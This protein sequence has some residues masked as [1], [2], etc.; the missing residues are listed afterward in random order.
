V[1]ELA[2]A[3]VALRARAGSRAP[4]P[5]VHRVA[6]DQEPTAATSSRR[7]GPLFPAAVIALYSALGIAAY[8]PLL[9]GASHRLPY[10][11]Y[12]DPV[13]VVWFFGWTAHALATAHNPFF[14]TAANVPYGVN[15]AQQTFAPLLGVLFAPLTLLV[16]PVSS[17]TACFVAAMP[18]SAASAYAVL[19]RWRLWAPAAALGGLAYGFSPFVVNQ[20]TQHLQFEF[21][22]LPPLIVACLV[23][24]VTRPRHPLRWGLALGGLVTAQFLISSEFL[25]ITAVVSVVGLVMTVAYRAQ[26]H[27]DDL[28]AAAG[29]ALRGAGTAAAVAGALLAYPIWYQFAGPGHYNGPPW[30]YLTGYNAHLLEFV[31]PTQNQLFHPALGASG[32]SF[33]ADSFLT[34]GAYL[35]FGVLV[36]VAVLG[37]LGRRSARMRLTATLG[38][39]S[40][41]LSFGPYTYVGGDH[42]VILPF[43]FLSK[44]PA[45]GDIIPIRFSFATAACV[46]AMLAFGLDGIHR[47]HPAGRSAIGPPEPTAHANRAAA[48]PANVALAAVWLVVGVTWLPAFPLTTQ[49]VRTLPTAVTRAIPAGDPTVLTYPYPRTSHDT[50]MLWQAAAGFSFRLVG[51]Y[52]MVPQPDGSPA[53]QS[54]PLDPP[55]VQVFLSAEEGAQG[56]GGLPLASLPGLAVETREFVVRQHVGAVLVSLAEPNAATVARVF[57]AA[58]GPPTL[59]TE[60]FELWVT[61]R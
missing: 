33:Y 42:R 27:R 48:W 60:G 41:L 47:Y 3:H 35:G 17:V 55:S 12:G 50:A 10:Q 21:L 43:Y 9:P 4:I 54:P 57:S 25:A 34:D 2:D 51:V 1:A 29:P 5:A 61:A 30:G 36:V 15:M 26:L 23:E 24:L 39:A 40:A 11:I 37:W 13:E 22:P 18:L 52:A 28:R 45:L 59:A 53:P 16:G 31:A 6:D 38:L 32:A 20:G 8:W 44:L 19:R 14:S 46:A 56:V 58:L 7:S 49:A